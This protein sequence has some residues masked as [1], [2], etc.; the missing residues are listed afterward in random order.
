MRST[1][2]SGRR[3]RTHTYGLGR[4]KTLVAY[5]NGVTIFAVALW[6][7]YEAA[8]RFLNPVPVLGGPMLV[9]AWPGSSSI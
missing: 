7:V 3:P 1:L 8:V 6:I 5:T 2:P 9:V 4:V